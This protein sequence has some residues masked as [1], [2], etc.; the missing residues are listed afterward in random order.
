MG[1]KSVI[2]YSSTASSKRCNGEENKR[3]HEF[4][5]AKCFQNKVSSSSRGPVGKGCVVTAYILLI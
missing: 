4:H 5:I 3:S 2:H 1:V